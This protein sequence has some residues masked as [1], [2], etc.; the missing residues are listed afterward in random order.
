MS[1]KTGSRCAIFE[2]IDQL[3]ESKSVK[4]LVARLKPIL[5]EMAYY[6]INSDGVVTETQEEW[7]EEYA[8][9]LFSE[10]GK[11]RGASEAK[12]RLDSGGPLQHPPPRKPRAAVKKPGSKARAALSG[13]GAGGMLEAAS[14]PVRLGPSASAS[15]LSR[16]SAANLPPSL[17]SIM[18][19][20]HASFREDDD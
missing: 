3:D 8:D 12:S 14:L 10:A 1:S 16:P 4:E 9:R 7:H 17:R 2:K 6:M 11:D 13:A 5:E 19:G 18:N 15:G 20:S